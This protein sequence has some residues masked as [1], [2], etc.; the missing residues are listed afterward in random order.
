MKNSG[1]AAVSTEKSSVP[2]VEDQKGGFQPIILTWTV[3][4]GNVTWH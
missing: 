3:F 1:M 4:K 2:I